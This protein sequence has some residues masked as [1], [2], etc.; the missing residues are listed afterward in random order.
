[1]SQIKGKNKR[2][3]MLVRRFLFGQGYNGDR[4]KIS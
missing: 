1:M 2:P 3:E 4:L